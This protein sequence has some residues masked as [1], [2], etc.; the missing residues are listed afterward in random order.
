MKTLKFDEVSPE[1]G[2]FFIRS[3]ASTVETI[4]E[5]LILENSSKS[6]F[7]KENLSK[8]CRSKKKKN[9]GWKN[10]FF[11]KWFPLKIDHFWDVSDEFWPGFLSKFHFSRSKSVF[12]LLFDFQN[13]LF[14]TFS[15]FSIIILIKTCH[16]PWENGRLYFI[17]TNLSLYIRFILWLWKKLVSFFLISKGSPCTKKQEFLI[18]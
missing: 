18:I 3:F 14:T 9:F 10:L 4:F 8:K 1:G 15:Q 7:Y 5:I 11:P 17:F 6:T 13:L 2:R 16:L 12:S